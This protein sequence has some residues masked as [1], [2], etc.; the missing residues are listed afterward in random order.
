MIAVPAVSFTTIALGDF[1]GRDTDLLSRVHGPVERA[2]EVSGL[3]STTTMSMLV[4]KLYKIER[5]ML[6][7]GVF[8]FELT[9]TAIFMEPQ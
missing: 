5:E 2:V 9:Q 6:L 1:F 3:Q 7:T 4:V 8:V